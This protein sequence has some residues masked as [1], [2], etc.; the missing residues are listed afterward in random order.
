LRVVG[1][2][3]LKR[4]LIILFFVFYIFIPIWAQDFGFGF[5]DEISQAGSGGDRPVAISGEVAT[6][7]IGY[8]DEMAEGAEHIKTVDMFMFSGKL[9]FLAQSPIAQ[10][11]IK[12][13]LVPSLVPISI[14]EAYIGAFYEG[15]DFSAGLKKVTWGKADQFGPLDVINLPDQSKIFIEMA[16]NSNLS[17]VKIAN[18]VIHASYRFGQ[19]SK[20]EG[21]FL[22][23][24]QIISMAVS[25]A[26][27]G[28]NEF[29]TLITGPASTE[30]WMPKE[31]D[32][33]NKMINGKDE[34]GNKLTAFSFEKTEATGLDYA[35]AGVRFTTT[36]GSAD[37]GMQ[38]FYGRMFQPAAKFYLAEKT[39]LP[40]I[41]FLFNIYHQIGIDYAQV[42][43]GFNVRAE[44][45]ANI[46]EDLD[47]SDGLIYNPSI[48]WSL[49]FDRDLFLG[50]NLNCQANGNVRLFNDKVGSSNIPFDPDFDNEAGKPVT[51]TRLTSMLSRKFLRDELELRAAV[52][53]GIEDKDFVII[54]SLIWTRD[55]LKA[56]FSG[57]FFLGD[58]DGQLGQYKNNN[59]LKASLAYT[60]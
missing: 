43:A 41:E 57:G 18:P 6:A 28:S 1:E 17:D 24:F 16:D 36:L 53:W 21:I 45:A 4:L 30:R 31:M 12:I 8:F 15:F 47:G 42:L 11:V 49:G 58:S 38:Y 50:I 32:A 55:G 52:V 44:A 10:G 22:P 35:Q 51:A 19:F 20:I 29:L 7:I 3:M 23:S 48:G 14:D 40:T 56:A 33:F 39:F 54:P 59:F 27:D 2:R 9:K 37:V 5:N 60:F 25:S 26:V 34:N 13:K 46:T